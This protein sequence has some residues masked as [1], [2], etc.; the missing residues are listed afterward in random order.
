[1]KTTLYLANWA[2][3]TDWALYEDDHDDCTN[4]EDLA[5]PVGSIFTKVEHAMAA[6]MEELVEHFQFT[7]DQDHLPTRWG[8]PTISEGETLVY[9]FNAKGKVIMALVI[10][11]VEIDILTS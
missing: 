8:S 6:A 1:M 4:M 7:E 10:R 11:A 3:P 9:C 2:T 5:R